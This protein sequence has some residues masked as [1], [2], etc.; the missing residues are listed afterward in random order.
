MGEIS[1]INIKG[2]EYF[3]LKPRFLYFILGTL[4]F[5]SILAF[6]YAFL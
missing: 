1:T 4:Y 2:K 5:A 6:I 3:L